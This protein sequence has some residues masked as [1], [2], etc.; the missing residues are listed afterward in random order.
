MASRAI[1]FDGRDCRWAFLA[2][3]PLRWTG[4]EAKFL[5]NYII[6][7]HN[8]TLNVTSWKIIIYSNFVQSFRNNLSKLAYFSMEEIVDHFSQNFRFDEP[9]LQWNF[10]KITQ[11][12]NKKWTGFQITTPLHS[13]TNITNVYEI[14]GQIPQFKHWLDFSD[15]FYLVN[16]TVSESTSNGMTTLHP[17]YIVIS[18]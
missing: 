1:G 16:S 5:K 8:L 17:Q 6:T 4:P 3:L 15:D 2:K 11:S 14:I 10:K 12:F 9:G 18:Y 7:V 13:M